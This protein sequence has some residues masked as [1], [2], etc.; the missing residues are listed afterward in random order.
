MI[1]WVVLFAFLLSI[2]IHAQLARSPKT[3]AE[4]FDTFRIMD[5]KLSELDAQLIQVDSVLQKA[6][7]GSIA[8]S[9]GKMARQPWATAGL[10]ILRNARTLNSRT[11]LLRRRYRTKNASKAL[12]TPLATSAK[13]LFSSARAFQ[14]SRTAREAERG[15]Q[16]LQRSRVDFL[17]AFH[18][19]TSDYGALRCQRGMWACCEIVPKEGAA[20]CHWDC[21][22]ESRKCTKGLIGPRSSAAGST[23]VH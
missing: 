9:S 5:G 14:R 10:Q 8:T 18:S 19:L 3:A 12:F 4:P 7:R 17:M 16:D 6:D 23:V 21:V 13:H 22:E 20:S 15:L 2:P 11:A 1:R